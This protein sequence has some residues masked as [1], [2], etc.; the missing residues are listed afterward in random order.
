MVVFL[1]W[2][3]YSEV[4]FQS[5]CARQVFNDIH[6]FDIS[7]MS[8]ALLRLQFFYNWACICPLFLFRDATGPSYLFLSKESSSTP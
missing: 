5:L 1:S 2:N 3:L 7:L 4:C 8:Y 6:K